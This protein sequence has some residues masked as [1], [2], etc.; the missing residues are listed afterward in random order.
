MSECIIC[1][2]RETIGEYVE[3]PTLTSLENLLERA[4]ER[5]KFKDSSVC[6]FI[7]RTNGQSAEDLK[8]NKSR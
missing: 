1:N 6:D 2:D 3:D 8:T 7:E 5:H 4:R